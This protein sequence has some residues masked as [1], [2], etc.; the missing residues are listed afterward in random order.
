LVG[1]NVGDV[2]SPEGQPRTRI[3]IRP[4]IAK[5]SR[6]GDVFLPDALGRKLKRFLRH[7]AGRRENLEPAAFL[8]RPQSGQRLS[9][10]RI[11]FAWRE[12]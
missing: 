4:E 12:R 9:P 8:R 11:Q 1:L 6:A 10:R 5:R 2:F 7:K 3:Y